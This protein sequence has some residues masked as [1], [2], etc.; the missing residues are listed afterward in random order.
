MGTHTATMRT[1]PVA[2]KREALNPCTDRSTS[3]SHTWRPRAQTITDV[4]RATGRAQ[5][6]SEG[7]VAV[8]TRRRVHLAC[9]W[10]DPPQMVL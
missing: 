5:W 1:T 7:P 3:S 6:H 10:A 2:A 9:L 8:D 4:K